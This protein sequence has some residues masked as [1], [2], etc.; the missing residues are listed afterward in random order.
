[1]TEYYL[2]ERRDGDAWSA[3]SPHFAT[4][5]EGLAALTL[6]R[7]AGMPGRFRLMRVKLTCVVEIP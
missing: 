7:D 3:Y 2:I 1:M 5:A 4:L 6:L